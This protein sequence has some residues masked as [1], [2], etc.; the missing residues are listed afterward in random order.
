MA[1]L[2]SWNVTDANNNGTPPSGFPENMAY[3]EVNNS[4]RAAMGAAARAYQDS[5]GTLVSTGS[6]NAYVVA[7]NVQYS[8]LSEAPRVVFKA[9]HAN[10]GAATLNVDGT[11]AAAIRDTHG[12]A[13]VEGQIVVNQLI[14]VCYDTVAGYYRALSIV[15]LLDGTGPATEGDMLVRGASGWELLAKGE[16]GQ[17]LMVGHP[18]FGYTGNPE[19]ITA[20]EVSEAIIVACSDETTALTTGKKA[21]F[22][23]PYA[24]NITEVVASLTTA[25]TSGNIFTVDV[26]VTWAGGP[27]GQTMFSTGLTIDNGETTSTT[28]TTAA[29]LDPSYTTLPGYT[30]VEVYIDQVGASADAAGLKVMLVGSKTL[31]G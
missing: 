19:W 15:P 10:T 31:V 26:H 5:N 23:T 16:Y 8:A 11:G 29:V 12:T 2:F 9:N 4:A 30:V 24:L 7:S 17:S 3:S 18:D 22:R 27:T 1:E 25:Q 6:A 21:T 28:A 14:S 20:P 13:L